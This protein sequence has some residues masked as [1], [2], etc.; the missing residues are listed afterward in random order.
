MADEGGK[1]L[2]GDIILASE[3]EGENNLGGRPR[4]YDSPEQF[5]E[6][7]DHAL[8]SHVEAGRPLTLTRLCLAMGFSGRR[9]LDNYL[10]YPEFVHSVTR[11][12]TIVQV[13]YEDS[14]LLDKNNA[15][16]KILGAM[17]THFNPATKIEG[18]GES[19]RHEDRLE[20]LR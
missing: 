3:Y 16:A 5:D 10:S 20:H 1:P 11:A 8:K 13:F 12:K 15:A 2:E 14:V 4:L 9:A 19:E 6:A 7:V 18:I 17:D